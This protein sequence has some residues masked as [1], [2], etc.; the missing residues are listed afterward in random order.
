MTLAGNVSFFMGA[1]TPDGFHSLFDGLYFPEKGWRLYIIKGGPGTGKSTLMK[2]IAH[3]CDRRGF[4]CERIFC[5]SDPD[6]LDAVIIPSLKIS[7]ADGTAP[8]VLEP[9]YP[10]VS[11]AFVDLGQFRNDRRLYE[12]RDIIIEKT[13]ENSFYHKKCTEFLFA[14]RACENDTASVVLPALKMDTLHRFS[15]KLALMK[16]GAASLPAGTVA[17]RFMSAYTSKGFISLQDTYSALCESSVTLTDTF[18]QASS[19]L[20]RV[21][22]L[23]AAERGMSGYVCLNPLFPDSRINQLIFPELSLGFTLK[24]RDDKPSQGLCVDCMRFYDKAYLSRHKNR[25]AFN[26]RSR[27]EMLSGASESLKKAKAVHDE[28]EAFYINAMDFDAM[29]EYSEK[30]VK[31]IFTR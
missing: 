2:K 28:L 16:L 27:E 15:E 24:E 29:N 26:R 9:K 6:S 19:V 23:K 25:L 14:A 1:S 8:H 4:F 10:G 11:E 5:S 31:E 21:L 17:K 30:V 7:I 22:M 13:K 18:S 3:E 12:N 20:M